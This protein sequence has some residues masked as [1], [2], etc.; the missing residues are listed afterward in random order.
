M[1]APVAYAQPQ[2]VRIRTLDDPT[3]LTI[4]GKAQAH[5]VISTSLFVM[6][7]DDCRGKWKG[8]SGIQGEIVLELLVETSGES[9]LKCCIFP[10][11]LSSINAK[12]NGII[13]NR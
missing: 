10:P 5:E 12:L 3:V 6:P 9:P 4:R 2:V 7:S 1:L 13:G 11:A 8:E